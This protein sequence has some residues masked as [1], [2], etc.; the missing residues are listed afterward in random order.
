MRLLYKQAMAK[1][2]KPTA[3]CLTFCLKRLKPSERE[4]AKTARLPPCFFRIKCVSGHATT[5]TNNV[6]PA[7]VVAIGWGA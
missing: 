4:T 7:V 6:D 3:F 5:S 2:S 1:G